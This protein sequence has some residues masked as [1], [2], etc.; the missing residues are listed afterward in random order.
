MTPPSPTVN[1]RLIDWKLMAHYFQ[2]NAEFPCHDKPSSLSIQDVQHLEKSDPKLFEEMMNEFQ[3]LNKRF[4]PSI[5]IKISQDKFENF[6]EYYNK[7]GGRNLHNALYVAIEKITDTNRLP[8]N[9]CM[10]MRSNEHFISWNK[11]LN[12]NEETALKKGLADFFNKNGVSPPAISLK[13]TQDLPF[14]ML[15]FSKGCQP[16]VPQV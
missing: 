10:W 2:A 1:P 6:L 7:V 16:P 13:F 4:I 12:A 11:K 5:P 8:M 14:Y 15:F 9:N 3:E